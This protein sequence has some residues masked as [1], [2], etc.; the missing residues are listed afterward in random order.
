MG[1]L[2]TA[3]PKAVRE[4]V[5][6]TTTGGRRALRWD[7]T[8][9]WVQLR[10]WKWSG[11]GSKGRRWIVPAPFLKARRGEDAPMMERGR[12]RRFSMT[13]R[14]REGGGGGWRCQVGPGCRW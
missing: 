7:A 9:R 5:R 2:T 8:A 12:G 10:E 1:K 3:K 13:V 14:V 11:E 4:R 6:Q